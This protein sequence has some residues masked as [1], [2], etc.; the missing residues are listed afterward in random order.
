[1]RRTTHMRR[2]LLRKGAQATMGQRALCMLLSAALAFSSMPSTALRAI[3]E[4]QDSTVAATDADLNED[5]RL[6]Q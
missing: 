5:T 3:A 1:M 2:E 4:E 6:E